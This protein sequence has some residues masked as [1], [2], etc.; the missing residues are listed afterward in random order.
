MADLNPVLVLTGCVLGLVCVVRLQH[1]WPCTFDFYGAFAGLMMVFVA[2]WIG[3]LRRPQGWLRVLGTIVGFSATAAY[4]LILK[5]LT[6][7]I[8]VFVFP[9]G[10]L[11]LFAFLIVVI[12]RFRVVPI[13]KPE[14][15]S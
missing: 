14:N 15:S 10:K 11:A 4:V 1:S 2:H 3:S 13:G 5:F 7:R 6:D 12:R 8:G 9:V